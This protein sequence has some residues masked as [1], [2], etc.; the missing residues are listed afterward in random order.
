MNPCLS[1]LEIDAFSVF[2]ILEVLVEST[3]NSLYFFCFP[4][5]HPQETFA[6]EIFQQ[7]CFEING[8]GDSNSPVI[9]LSREQWV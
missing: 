3:T 8:D 7:L 6:L 2:H 5:Q 9:T 1:N 4:A